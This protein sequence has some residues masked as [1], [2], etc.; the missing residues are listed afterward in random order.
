M[1]KKL[2]KGG[3]RTNLMIHFDILHLFPHLAT[4]MVLNRCGSML[5]I[6]IDIDL[7]L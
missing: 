5:L 3:R 7:S 2:T 6:F 4:S 1:L